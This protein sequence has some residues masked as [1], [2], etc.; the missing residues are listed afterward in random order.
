MRPKSPIVCQLD[1]LQAE[2]AKLLKTLGFSR[3]GRTFKR[4]TEPGLLQIIAL[5]AGPFE[6]GPAL[7]EPVS[8]LRPD[9]YGKFTVNIGVFVDEI[10]E[11]NNPPLKLGR[12]ISDAHCAIR[13]RLGHITDIE[14][15]WWSLLDGLDDTTEEVG[16]LLLHVGV[17][18]LDR[19]GSREK[20]IAEWQNF[21]ER[22]LRITN[23]ARLHVAAVLLKRND[24]SGA[25]NLFQLHLNE[26]QQEKHLPHV[27]NHILYV[28]ELAAKLGIDPLS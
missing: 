8:H 18:F 11:L 14:D 12:V 24:R 9:Y 2:L 28:R 4:E 22:E 7:P 25:T 13:T 19:F 3:K 26:C 27:R 5:Q 21:N 1:I 6:I 23:V 17:P 15:R 10:Y 20:I 16:S